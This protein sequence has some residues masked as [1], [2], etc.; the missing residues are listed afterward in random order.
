MKNPQL[1]L[2]MVVKEIKDVLTEL[3][4]EGIKYEKVG[5]SEYYK[6]EL[7]AEEEIE[8]Y[9]EYLYKVKNNDKTLI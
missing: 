5:E 6:M 8:G 3:M 7:F 4:V 1:F 2:D 9:K